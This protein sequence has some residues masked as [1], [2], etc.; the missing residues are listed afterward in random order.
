M[1]LGLGMWN[2]GGPLEDLS[3]SF[4]L[5]FVK[6]QVREPEIFGFDLLIQCGI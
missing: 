3:F 2:W 1:G 6:R 4:C 5:S